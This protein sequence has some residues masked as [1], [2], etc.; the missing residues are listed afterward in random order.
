MLNF[1]VKQSFMKNKLSAT[2]QVRDVLGTA[3]HEYITD[4]VNLYS[5]GLMEREAPIISL[6]LRY[7]FNNFREK[8]SSMRSN[9]G[10]GF[11][12]DDENIITNFHN[13]TKI[14]KPRYFFRGFL[15]CV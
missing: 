8:K 2:L 10:G 4:T 1:A 15:L 5:H 7:N 14:Q 6:N 3:K 13:L 12:S 9:D 11:D